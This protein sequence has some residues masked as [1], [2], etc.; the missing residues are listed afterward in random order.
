MVMLSSASRIFFTLALH[1]AP[2]HLGR[3]AQR[4]KEPRRIEE[5]NFVRAD[6][7]EAAHELLTQP[8]RPGGSTR[9]A[10]A[11]SSDQVGLLAQE[12][13]QNLAEPADNQ[14]GPDLGPFVRRA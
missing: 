4:R 11:R 9:L 7:D 2:R 6:P 5:R 1:D 3:D 8:R 14:V 13:G 12:P 10:R